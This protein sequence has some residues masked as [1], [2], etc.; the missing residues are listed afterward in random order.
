MALSRAIQSRLP[1]G[2]MSWAEPALVTQI[3]LHVH[4]HAGSDQASQRIV[5]IDHQLDRDALNHLGE[6]A[7]SVVRREQTELGARGGE[8]A[9]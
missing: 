1:G 8:K 9:L 6:V 4:R 7:G 5:F 2:G 3:D